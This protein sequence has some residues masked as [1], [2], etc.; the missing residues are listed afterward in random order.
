[1]TFVWIAAGSFALALVILGAFMYP[2][3][4]LHA[5]IDDETWPDLWDENE[6][7]RR[8]YEREHPEPER[9][10]SHG[11]TPDW[12]WPRGYGGDNSVPW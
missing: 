12:H 8:K 7:E 4:D 5:E 1:M 2:W 11:R 9:P 10:D 6:A 3:S